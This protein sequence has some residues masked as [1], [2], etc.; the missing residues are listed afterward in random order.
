RERFGTPMDREKGKEAM[1]NFVP[2]AGR[3]RIM[4]DRDRHLLFIGQVLQFLLPET[5]ADPIGTASIGANEQFARF[6][7]ELLARLL[8]PSSDAFPSKFRRVKIVA[9]IHKATMM[10]QN[11][12][13]VG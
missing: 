13:A 7:R 9:H 1:L 6:W 11:R 12:N 10:S 8:P 2:F 4:H 5:I 3:R